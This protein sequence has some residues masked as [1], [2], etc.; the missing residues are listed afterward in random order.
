M[1]DAPKSIYGLSGD[2]WLKYCRLVSEK[3]NDFFDED[4]EII[5]LRNVL[6]TFCNLDT[7]DPIFAKLGEK[8]I[9]N[10]Y[11]RKMQ[12]TEIVPELNSSYGK[13]LFDQQGINQITWVVDRL[14]N[15][16]ETKAA[17]ISL[18]LPD[19][20]GPRI[21][22]LCILDFKIRDGKLRL[23]GFFRSQNIINSYANFISIRDLH[24][25]IASKLGIVVGEMT[26]LVSSA[27]Y[28]KKD[29]MRLNKILNFDESN[30]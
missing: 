28:Y 13:R 4:Q 12:T 27:H 14:T 2:V 24:Y 5:E 17:T 1:S 9:I 18:L 26:F 23:T 20:P 6:L 22:C 21:P 8:Q 10:L 19:D 7:E 3:G 29:R 15:K 16:P 25:D 30:I 11:R